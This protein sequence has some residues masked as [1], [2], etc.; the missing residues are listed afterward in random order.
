M[1][2]T[3][4]L[5][6]LYENKTIT[7]AASDGSRFI[8]AAASTFT[9]GIDQR[10]TKWGLNKPGNATPATD[11]SVFKIIEDT[12]F[13]EIYSSLSPDLNKLCFTQ[14][15]IIEFCERHRSKLRKGGYATFFFFKEGDW[16]Y[17]T[18]V[19]VV[20][21]G[22]NVYISHLGNDLVWGAFCTRRV[23]VPQFTA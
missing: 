23:V 15:Q 9:A 13:P 19:L 22:L 17:I 6:R 2:P 20:T 16:F 10:F 3:P 21:D 7:L 18:R 1:Q 8:S 12:T 11:V 4:I 14:D 5:R